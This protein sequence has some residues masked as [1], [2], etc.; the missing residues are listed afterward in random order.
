MPASSSDDDLDLAIF[1]SRIGDAGISPHP[2]E[3]DI[4]KRK[5]ACQGFFDRRFL[6]LNEVSHLIEFGL[7]TSMDFD[8]YWIV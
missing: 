4:G 7:V 8:R 6:I 2:P 3:R 1:I 5:E